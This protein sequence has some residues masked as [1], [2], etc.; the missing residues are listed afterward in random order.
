MGT[1]SRV[2]VNSQQR[3]RP[4]RGSLWRERKQR[5]AGSLNEFPEKDVSVS[6]EDSYGKASH[7]RISKERREGQQ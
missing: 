5:K 1:E 2:E 6:K 7:E 3:R 4:G